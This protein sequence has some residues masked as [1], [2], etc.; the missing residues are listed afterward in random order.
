[1]FYT[2]LNTNRNKHNSAYRAVGNK[3]AEL[4]PSQEKMCLFW[5]FRKQI[6]PLAL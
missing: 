3:N 2:L 1:M 5:I 4:K 6:V